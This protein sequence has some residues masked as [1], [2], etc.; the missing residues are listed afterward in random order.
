MGIDKRLKSV[1]VLK[2]RRILIVSLI[3]CIFFFVSCFAVAIISNSLAL[4]IDAAFIFFDICLVTITIA[5]LEKIFRRADKKYNFGY[6]KL[7]PLIVLIQC[8]F[9]IGICII[10]FCVAIQQIIYV[11]GGGM[12]EVQAYWATLSFTSFSALACLGMLWYAKIV[13]KKHSSA[14]LQANLLVY[15]IDFYICAGLLVGFLISYFLHQYGLDFIAEFADPVMSI[16][17]CLCMIKEPYDLLVDSLRD[18]L[19]ICPGEELGTQLLFTINQ[20]LIKQC[21]LKGKAKIKIRKAGRR[22]FIVMNYPVEKEMSFKDVHDIN[23]K[24]KSYFESEFPGFHITCHPEL[25]K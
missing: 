9:L 21:H 5:W 8:L 19:D 10:G 13:T 2:E 16:L 1:S 12:L 6:F 11:A 15:K 3:V 17:I 25:R 14:I 4:S 23:E 20:F 22:H 18:L 7:E 24:I